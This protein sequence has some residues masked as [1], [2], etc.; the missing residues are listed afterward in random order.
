MSPV[1]IRRLAALSLSVSALALGSAAFGQSGAPSGAQAGATKDDCGPQARPCGPLIDDS[2]VQRRDVAPNLEQGPAGGAFRVSIDGRP[3]Q[4]AADD[5]R[6]ADVALAG[7]KIDVQVT[8]LDGRPSLSV[9]SSTP[10]AA[11]GL[12]VAFHVFT[13]YAAFIARAE[14]RI[15][16]P[17]DSLSGC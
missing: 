13:N 9:V 14:L 1:S 8:T 2:T 11:A 3:G 7:A 5:Q 10:T 15:F 4:G 16:G 12:P 17:D 6:A